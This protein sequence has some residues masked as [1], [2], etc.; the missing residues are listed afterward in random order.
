VELPTSRGIR[1][2]DPNMRVVDSSVYWTARALRSAGRNKYTSLRKTVCGRSRISGLLV[3][4]IRSFTVVM[5]WRTLSNTSQYTKQLYASTDRRDSPARLA[6]FEGSMSTV[7][8][9]LPCSRYYNKHANCLS[10]LAQRWPDK[11]SVFLRP[12]CKT[13]S[14]IIRSLCSQAKSS[15]FTYEIDINKI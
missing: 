14:N 6:C 15:P 1:T 10:R 3:R 11:F 7:K 12:S 4:R 8:P 2:H 13:P 5:S 9:E